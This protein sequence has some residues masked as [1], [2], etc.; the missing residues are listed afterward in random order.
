[1]SFPPIGVLWRASRKRVEKSL[2]PARDGN[3]GGAFQQSIL[4]FIPYVTRLFN[5]EV[6]HPDK[7]D[8][9]TS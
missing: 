7:A 1:M 8:K 5:K 3:D 4:L 6:E 9:K 2:D